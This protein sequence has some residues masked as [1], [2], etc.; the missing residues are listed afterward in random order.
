MFVV[1]LQFHLILLFVSAFGGIIISETY[2][3][4]SLYYNIR[5]ICFRRQNTAFALA[6]YV[7]STAL[8]VVL[9]WIIT[10][11]KKKIFFSYKLSNNNEGSKTRKKILR[12]K[13]R[14]K[15]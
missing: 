10:D 13:K 12:K 15:E 9:S 3:F 6:F 4:V 11:N 14:K 7:Y 8:N 1:C 5:Q 2:I